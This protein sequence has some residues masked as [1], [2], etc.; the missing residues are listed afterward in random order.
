MIDFSGYSNEYLGSITEVN[1]LM[2][3]KIYT[4]QKKGLSTV[5]FLT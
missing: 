3:L 4:S 2:S 5:E 1:F